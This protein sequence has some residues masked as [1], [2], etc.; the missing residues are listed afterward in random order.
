MN[1]KGILMGGFILLLLLII[2]GMKWL[3]DQQSNGEEPTNASQTTSTSSLSTESSIPEQ[4]TEEET[5]IDKRIDQMSL[6]EKVGQLF[7][8]RVPEINQVEDIQT[9]HLGGYVLF[10]RDTENETAETL[11]QKIADYQQASSIPLLIGM[12]E[13][14]GTVTRISRNPALVQTPFLSPQQLYQQGGWQ[15]IEEDTAQKAAIFHEY[16]ISTGLFPVADVSTDPNSFIYDRT[17]GLDAAG[18][19]EF[20]RRNIAVLKENR[21]GSTLKHFP[22]Y[23]NNRDSHV[24]IVTDDRPLEELET[25]DFL[26][27]EAGIKAGADSIL[28]SHNI[29]TSIDDSAPASISKPVHELLR[30]QLGFKGV[31]MTDDMDMAGLADFISQSEAG[32]RALEAGNDLVMSSTYQQQIPVIVEAVRSGNYP[33]A[34]IDASVKRVLEWKASIGLI[35]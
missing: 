33:E 22:G 5:T 13:E 16:G 30:K 21:I 12:D 3:M 6:E 17:I 32:L 20:V 29:V 9:Y 24:E 2:G 23:G 28:V 14:G 11:K 31:I 34:A 19:S 10:G 35:N 7:F 8:V 26:P 4:S 18:T 25:N 1:K 27:F 15:A